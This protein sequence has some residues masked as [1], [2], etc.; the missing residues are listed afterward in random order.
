MESAIRDCIPLLR[1][2]AVPLRDGVRNLLELL[3]QVHETDPRLSR[4]IE[5]QVGQMPVVPEGLAGYKRNHVATLEEI[6]SKR[7]DVRPGP[8]ALMAVLLAAVTETV[9]VILVHATP[10]RFGRD[11]TLDEA[12][13]VLCRYVERP[14]G[15][16]S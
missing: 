3:R 14:A 6:L 4:A 11:E 15:R 7:P 12:V 2:P 1:D 13:E 9:S 5:Q 16:A 10:D 8:H